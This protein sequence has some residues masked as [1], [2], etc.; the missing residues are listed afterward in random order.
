MCVTC[1][2]LLWSGQIPAK[3]PSHGQDDSRARRT[4]TNKMAEVVD[5]IF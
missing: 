5:H 4:L 2:D 1:H 3:A